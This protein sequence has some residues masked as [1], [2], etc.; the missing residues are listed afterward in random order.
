MYMTSHPKNLCRW[1]SRMINS[2]IVSAL[3]Q[4]GNTKTVTRTYAE[5]GL[6]NKAVVQGL[7]SQRQL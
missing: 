7:R 4:Q 1:L 5:P 3:P 2:A 6:T